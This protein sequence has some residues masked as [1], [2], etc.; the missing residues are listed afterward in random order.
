MKI[1][2]ESAGKEPSS[3][4]R[5]TQTF[6]R[7]CLG[8]STPSVAPGTRRS[9]PKQS[10]NFADRRFWHETTVR[11]NRIA[12]GMSRMSSDSGRCSDSNRLNSGRSYKARSDGIGDEGSSGAGEADH[13]RSGVQEVR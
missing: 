1:W 2:Y 4:T 9:S 6:Y 13:H 12:T 11:P 5:P 8:F 7:N 10:F 3:G